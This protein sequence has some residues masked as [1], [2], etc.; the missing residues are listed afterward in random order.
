MSF[1]PVIARCKKCGRGFVTIGTD[2]SMRDAY[3]D[4]NWRHPRRSGTARAD[5][6]P[7]CGGDIELIEEG[8]CMQEEVKTFSRRPLGLKDRIGEIRKL[9]RQGL[10]Q[11]EV[12]IQIGCSVR[13]IQVTAK[14]YGVTFNASQ[15][16]SPQSS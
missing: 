16:R 6:W 9:A 2:P 13:S 3:G 14:K 4:P 5:E 15:R 12:A 1:F 11:A 8:E 10:S 7:A